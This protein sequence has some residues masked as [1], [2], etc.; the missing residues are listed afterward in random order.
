MLASRGL[1]DLRNAR[2]VPGAILLLVEGLAVEGARGGGYAGQDGEGEK[3][4]QEGLHDHSLY[5]V[6]RPVA[7]RCSRICNM[8]LFAV[9]KRCH[10]SSVMN[11]DQGA[12]RALAQ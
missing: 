4:G 1:H 2:L 6:V 5:F 7:S 3:R 12:S 9:A 8:V 11:G 10:H